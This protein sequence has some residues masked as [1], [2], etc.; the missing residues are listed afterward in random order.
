MLILVLMR[1]GL[2][3][4]RGLVPLLLLS[5][6]QPF[7]PRPLPRLPGFYR[8]SERPFEPGRRP[9]NGFLFSGRRLRRCLQ[10]ERRVSQQSR[11][12]ICDVRVAAYISTCIRAYTSLCIFVFPSLSSHTNIGVVYAVL[13][14]M[15]LR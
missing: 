7:P 12:F 3:L 11:A 8:G 5:R 10:V 15:Y 6:P 1:P 2:N 4:V 14:C 13:V 9:A